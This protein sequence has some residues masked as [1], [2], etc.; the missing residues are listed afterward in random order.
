M[1]V[2]SKVGGQH[3]LDTMFLYFDVGTF[4][5]CMFIKVLHALCSYASF[6]RLSVTCV[7]RSH[8]ITSY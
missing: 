8:E 6:L 7:E 2:E 5:G 3:H 1:T 4:R